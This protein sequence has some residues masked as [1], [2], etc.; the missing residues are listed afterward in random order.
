M[1]SIFKNIMFVN[2]FLMFNINLLT[3]NIDTSIV[4]LS[5]LLWQLVISFHANLPAVQ[6]HIHPNESLKAIVFMI[7]K[8][9]TIDNG[10]LK[11]I[12]YRIK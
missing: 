2:I 11:T 6:V 7:K 10:S 5:L 1:I 4:Y 12:C 9:Y 8:G 3:F